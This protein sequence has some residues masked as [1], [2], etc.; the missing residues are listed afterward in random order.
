MQ[1]DQ[2][3]KLFQYMTERFDAL[4]SK[5]DAKAEKNQVEQLRNVI[6]GAAADISDVKDEFVIHNHQIDRRLNQNEAWITQL[7][8]HQQV[9]LEPES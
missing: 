4:E 7:A 3:T 2:F 5:V 8:D 6:D 1:D 9:K